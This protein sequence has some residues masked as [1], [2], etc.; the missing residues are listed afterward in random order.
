MLICFQTHSLSNNVVLQVYK[1]TGDVKS[2]Q[3]MFNKYSEV[4]DEGRYPWA[5]W[6]SIILAHKQPR[7]IMVQHNSKL[8]GK[9]SLC[10]NYLNNAWKNY[11]YINNYD[12]CFCF[13][14]LQGALLNS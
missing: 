5:K 7:K 9:L 6:R 3:E 8:N 14:S 2:A 12:F 4:S 13:M 1:S 10:K 11:R